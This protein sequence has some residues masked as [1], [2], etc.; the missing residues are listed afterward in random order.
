M[1]NFLFFIGSLT[2]AI[3][4]AFGVNAWL[5]HYDNPGYVLIG[6]GHWS[7]ETSLMVFSTALIV[8][9]FLF[10]FF[11]R[12]LGILLRLP[13]KLKNRADHARVNRSQQALLAGLVDSAEGNWEQAEKIL[14]RH[15]SNSGAPLIHYLTAARAAQSRG[16]VEQRDRYL[17]LAREQGKG[18]ELAVGLTQAELS[19]SEQQ[20]DE[21][22]STLTKLQSID[23]EH[24]SVLRLLHQ[25]YRQMGDWHGLRQLLPDLQKKKVLMEAEVK[26]L[27]TETFS[28]LLRQGAQARD[29]EAITH[30][31]QE[32][33]EHIKTL[34]GIPAIYFAAMIECGAG[35]DIEAELAETLSTQWD[36]TL[37]VLY[38][39][40]QGA[41]PRKQL[42]MAEGWL[43]V[44]PDNAI[45]LRVTGKLAM[46]AQVFGEAE[47]YL[48]KS[49]ALEPTV[50]GYQLLGEVALEKQDTVNALECYRAGL[51]LASGEVLEQLE[52]FRP[53]D[54]ET[55]PSES[56]AR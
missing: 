36:D 3:V 5:S 27:Q 48:A 39:S 17:E 41:N 40:F 29:R 7:M 34:H 26:L 28:N 42:E 15:A 22:L 43:E 9:F 37:A 51:E 1:K 46:Q 4:A 38:G 44:Y 47:R 49:L 20:F 11:F 13:G 10:Y 18:S 30:L 56:E 12:M 33:P 8:V 35:A 19:L 23:P 45:L 24:A 53:Q 55:E 50:A 2:I 21:A 25:T 54:S 16:A 32:I 6:M 52:S 14:I 31:W